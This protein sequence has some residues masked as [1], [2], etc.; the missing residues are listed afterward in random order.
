MTAE[1]T[2]ELAWFDD[3]PDTADD[4]QHPVDRCHR[5]LE[6]KLRSE[7]RLSP[8]WDELTRFPVHLADHL[9]RGREQLGAAVPLR[10]RDVWLLRWLSAGMPE[11]QLEGQPKEWRFRVAD[12]AK[13]ADRIA[14]A[15]RKK[16][17]A[18]AIEDDLQFGTFLD[19]DP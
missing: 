13:L 14:S 5:R 17:H 16:D 1:T 7:H 18:E 10:Q 6:E 8:G 4:R 19:E 2:E 9:K 15:N 3:C 12:A 11:L